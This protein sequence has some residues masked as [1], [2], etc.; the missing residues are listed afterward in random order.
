M[1]NTQPWVLADYKDKVRQNFNF[2]I[3]KSPPPLVKASGD[4]R[5][6][7]RVLRTSPVFSFTRD[8]IPGE[9]QEER[10]RLAIE[11]YWVMHNSNA[12][13]ASWAS[14]LYTPR[15]PQIML[16]TDNQTLC[17][18]YFCRPIC[19]WPMYRASL[20]LELQRGL[21]GSNTAQKNIPSANLY[22]AL[23]FS[24]ALFTKF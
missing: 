20:W 16:Y 9:S 10:N 13:K 2:Y 23:A 7:Q 14:A 1:Y 17:S 5:P 22:A 21:K 3:V 12:T 19:F 8:D 11:R 24:L 15:L 4:E 18:L 6:R